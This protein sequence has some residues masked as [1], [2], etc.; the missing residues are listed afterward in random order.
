MLS[1]TWPSCVD[2]GQLPRQGPLR[3]TEHA[4]VDG[5]SFDGA[6]TADHAV[7]PE[8]DPRLHTDPARGAAWI[9]EAAREAVEA[10]RAAL[11]S[12]RGGQAG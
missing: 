9:E 4:V 10:I 2:L 12:A 6:P 11:A 7:R 1:A 8:Q 5:D 3:N